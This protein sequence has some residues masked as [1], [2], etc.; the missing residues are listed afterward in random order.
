MPPIQFAEG[1]KHFTAANQ[2]RVDIVRQIP[3][4]VALV[5]LFMEGFVAGLYRQR[6]AST[7]RQSLH[8]HSRRVLGTDL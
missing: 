8:F 5:I 2:E 6:Y 4:L 7:P 1:E 3:G